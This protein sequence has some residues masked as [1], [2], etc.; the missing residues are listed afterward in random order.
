M[1]NID[2]DQLESVKTMNEASIARM[3]EKFA[4]SCCEPEDLLVFAIDEVSFLTADSLWQID[5][6]LSRLTG[7]K[8]VEFGGVLLIAAGVRWRSL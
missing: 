8:D 5:Q 7:H 2:F 3:R 4:A 6:Q 1:L